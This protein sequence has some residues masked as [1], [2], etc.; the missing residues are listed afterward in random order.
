MLNRSN[1]N[2]TT[3]TIKY[4]RKWCIIVVGCL[5]FITS[6]EHKK[7]IKITKFIVE[8]KRYQKRITADY[9]IFSIYNMTFV[10]MGLVS[11]YFISGKYS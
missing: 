10:H 2:L 6:D 8:F 1:K 11:F 4:T 9:V 5:V 3:K 7:K